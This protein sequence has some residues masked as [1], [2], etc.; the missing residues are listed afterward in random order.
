MLDHQAAWALFE[1]GSIDGNICAYCVTKLRWFNTDQLA[2][3][4]VKS[5]LRFPGYFLVTE[6]GVQIQPLWKQW[7]APL[8][9]GSAEQLPRMAGAS[10]C[11]ITHLYKEASERA[12]VCP[13]PRSVLSHTTSNFSIH[14]RYRSPFIATHNMPS[15]LALIYLHRQRFR[16]YCATRWWIGPIAQRVR[17]ASAKS[18]IKD[19]WNGGP[20]C[21][22]MSVYARVEACT[23]RSL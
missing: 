19:H 5:R 2:D 6:N 17:L 7:A 22:Q 20:I 18:C 15:A 9:A 23:L 14:I 3:T 16:Q 11:P 21:G 13:F 10:G 12:V 1:K 8:T 4:P